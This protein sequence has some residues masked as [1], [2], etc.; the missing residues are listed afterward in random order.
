[1]Q[2]RRWVDVV[3]GVGRVLLAL[4]AREAYRGVLG[5]GSW[6]VWGNETYDGEEAEAAV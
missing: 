1:M 2:S 6:R 5:V 4:A 3:C